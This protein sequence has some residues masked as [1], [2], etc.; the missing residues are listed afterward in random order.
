MNSH[1]TEHATPED[2]AAL[3]EATLRALAASTDPAAFRH[4][5][6]LTEVVGDCLAV[7]A[8]TLADESSWSGVAGIAGTTR[9]AAWARWRPH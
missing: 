4:L 6:R 3:A 2:L 5:L 1:G 9:Q 7:A 8:R